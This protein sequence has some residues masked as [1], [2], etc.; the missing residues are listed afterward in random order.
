MIIASHNH[1]GFCLFVCFVKIQIRSRFWVK[2]ECENLWMK[3]LVVPAGSWI[4]HGCWNMATARWGVSAGK[5]DWLSC[6]RRQTEQNNIFNVKELRG[7]WAQAGDVDPVCV[8]VV[9]GL[10]LPEA[11]HPQSAFW[12]G[13]AP[14]HVH[15][16]ALNK[17]QWAEATG[18]LAPLLPLWQTLGEESHE[19]FGK[20]KRLDRINFSPS[21]KIWLITCF[22]ALANRRMLTLQKCQE[23]AELVETPCRY[24]CVW[25]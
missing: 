24:Y 3:C 13:L 2:A 25:I 5:P 16:R 20:A 4:C 10:S 11:A 6:V 7:K 8:S 14:T 12:M 9:E 21:L 17:S 18:A 1:E 23:P 19:H 22:G 15:A